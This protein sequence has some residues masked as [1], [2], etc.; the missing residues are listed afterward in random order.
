MENK[1]RAMLFFGVMFFVLILVTFYG[2]NQANGAAT[3][4]LELQQK[5]M[6]TSKQCSNN[7]DAL[8]EAGQLNCEWIEC[9]ERCQVGKPEPYCKELI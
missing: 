1:N 7:C 4:A 5:Q 3:K 6:N 8:A 9:H 2:V